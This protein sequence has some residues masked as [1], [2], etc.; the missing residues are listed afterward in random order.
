[1]RLPYNGPICKF[2][3]GLAG[4]EGNRQ[5][6]EPSIIRSASESLEIMG[7]KDHL[8]NPINLYQ[9]TIKIDSAGD[10]ET[11]SHTIIRTG[12]LH[13]VEAAKEYIKAMI[14][15]APD[16]DEPTYIKG[17]LILVDN[18]MLLHIDPTNTIHEA[19]LLKNHKEYLKE[20]LKELE[21]EKLDNEKTYIFYLNF[22]D[23]DYGLAKPSQDH[24]DSLMYLRNAL[25]KRIDKLIKLEQDHE[26]KQANGANLEKIEFF[27]K[28]FEEVSAYED[29]HVGIDGLNMAF[30]LQ[31]LCR[32][33]GIPYSEGC[34]SNK[35]RGG[36]KKRD[37]HK[38]CVN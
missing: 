21:K 14:S 23:K 33:L 15:L 17:E 25:K 12:A 28:L 22:Q 3:T 4:P 36:M 16:K 2:I 7:N 27:Y 13:S 38:F 24:Y 11:I 31:Y 29:R 35:D 32:S 9:H 19:P 34:K 26:L 5:A 10:S 1:M 30:L 8:K 18:R 37:W 20:A 6:I